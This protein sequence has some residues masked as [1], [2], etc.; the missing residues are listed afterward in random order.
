MQ[1]TSENGSVLVANQQLMLCCML[2]LM[3]GG[4]ASATLLDRGPNMV[5]DNVLNI[6]WT[7]NANLPG[8][9]SVTWQQAKDWAAN[10]VFVGYDDW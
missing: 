10:L 2:G 3:V 4:G 5:Y 1:I 6:T 9:G 7:R 8:S